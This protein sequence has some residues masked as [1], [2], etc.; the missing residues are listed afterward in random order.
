MTHHF[1]I[2]H[3]VEFY[4]TDMAGIVHFS[5][6]FRWMESAETS[7][8]KKLGIP[9]TK[10]NETVITGW[11]KVS[12]S[13]NFTAPLRFQDEV[14]IELTVSKIGNSALS[15]S[16]QF[17]KIENDRRTKVGNSEM[18]TVYAKFNI[19]E[20]TMAASLMEEQ[21]RNKLEKVATK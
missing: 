6:Y 10:K 14:E 15:Y 20:G 19:S 3:S 2:K 13:C 12:T 21:L 18:T 7:F 16:F 8:F 9:V 17:F 5:N 1:S 11:P 4:E